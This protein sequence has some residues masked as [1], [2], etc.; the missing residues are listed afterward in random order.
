MTE[1]WADVPAARPL[2][3]TRRGVER[4]QLVALVRRPVRSPAGRPLV[5]AAG[6][7]ALAAVTGAA[8]EYFGSD[9]VTD[10]SEVQCHTTVEVARGAEYAGAGV[11]LRAPVEVGAGEPSVSIQDA[12]S[13]CADLWEQGVLRPGQ[14]AQDP[15]G[16][17]E[18]VPP[19]TA[20]LTEHGVAAVFP[21]DQD[22]CASLGLR[23]LTR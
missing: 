5:L 1:W 19:L 2:P 13:A 21:T 7:L 4:A 16:Q 17:V 6:G 11:Q 18:A 20:C 23:G 15:T 3:A 22:V 10:R 8:F 14:N 9:E 12:V